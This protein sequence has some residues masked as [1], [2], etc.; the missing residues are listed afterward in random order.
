MWSRLGDEARGADWLLHT[1]LGKM[2]HGAASNEAV[3]NSRSR[4]TAVCGGL[5]E[6]TALGAVLPPLA[7]APITRREE[8]ELFFVVFVRACGCNLHLCEECPV[9]EPGVGSK[10]R[11]VFVPRGLTIPQ[12]LVMHVSPS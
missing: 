8:L 4:T 2:K 11:F 7:P 1:P 5:S 6:M 12:I 10:A 9:P 3:E